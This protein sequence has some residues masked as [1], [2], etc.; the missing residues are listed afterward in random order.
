MRGDARPA[1][2]PTLGMQLEILS[3]SYISILI[4][5]T[6]TACWPLCVSWLLIKVRGEI[7]IQILSLSDCKRGFDLVCHSQRMSNNNI[8]TN[9]SSSLPTCSYRHIPIE[10][11]S[12]QSSNFWIFARDM[13]K[14]VVLLFYLFYLYF[15]RRSH[16]DQD[17]SYKRD[18]S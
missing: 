9:M 10:R 11:C 1:T 15:A 17:V 8:Y 3:V 18:M 12:S 7:V 16:W 2:H 6:V 4:K 14:L 13:W 5:I